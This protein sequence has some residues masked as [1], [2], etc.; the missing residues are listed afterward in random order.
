MYAVLLSSDIKHLH[1]SLEAVN[2]ANH[3]GK[4]G[5]GNWKVLQNISYL[6]VTPEVPSK[7]G[8]SVLNSELIKPQKAKTEDMEAP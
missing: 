7:L 4:Q 8:L 6:L 2:F 1:A 3:T 5:K